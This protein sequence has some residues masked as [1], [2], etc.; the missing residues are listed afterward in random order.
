MYTTLQNMCMIEGGSGQD[1]SH[2]WLG[3]EVMTH[4]KVLDVAK[5]QCALENSK[6]TARLSR[7]QFSLS[8]FETRAFCLLKRHNFVKQSLNSLYKLNWFLFQQ[9]IFFTCYI[10]HLLYRSCCLGG[11]RLAH[12]LGKGSGWTGKHRVKSRTHMGPRFQLPGKQR[13]Q[14]TRLGQW[15]IAGRWSWTLILEM[16]RRFL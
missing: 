9:I 15:G 6:V 5:L 4:W 2:Q 12:R 3:R 10:L 1:K 16:F 8:R 13:R 14:Y 11:L 7:R